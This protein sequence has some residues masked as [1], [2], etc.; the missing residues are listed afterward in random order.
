MADAYAELLLLIEK[1]Q[2]R[3][4]SKNTKRESFSSIYDEGGIP[5]THA[6]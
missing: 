1:L 4:P 6:R 5:A 2:I 3:E